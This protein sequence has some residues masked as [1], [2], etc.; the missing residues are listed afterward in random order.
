MGSASRDGHQFEHKFSKVK[1]TRVVNLLGNILLKKYPKFC[2]YHA[3]VVPLADL[4]EW[5]LW[6]AYITIYGIP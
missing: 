5:E 3:H 6:P 2:A 1:S 4:L